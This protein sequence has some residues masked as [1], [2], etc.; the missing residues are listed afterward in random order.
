MDME[1]QKPLNRSGQSGSAK[2]NILPST[3]KFV[4]AIMEG[5]RGGRKIF[6]VFLLII[7]F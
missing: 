3:K 4:A 2:I 6:R 7:L 5:V 1:M